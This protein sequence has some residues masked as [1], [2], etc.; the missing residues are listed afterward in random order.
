MWASEWVGLPHEKMG[1]GPAAYD[2]LGL[3]LALHRARFGRIIPDP[4]CTMEQATR[5]RTAEALR[6]LWDRVEPREVAEGDALLFRVRGHIL[7]VGYALDRRDMLHSEHGS[8]IERWDST[9]WRGR[10]EGCYRYAD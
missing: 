3:F 4:G 5:E 9:R 2:C 6:P 1:R 7:H 8:L 10:L